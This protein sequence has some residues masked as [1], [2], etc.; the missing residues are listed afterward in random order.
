MSNNSLKEDLFS[1]SKLVLSA[2]KG[3]KKKER[4][5]RRT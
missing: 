3:G 1:E 4:I 2:R 5:H